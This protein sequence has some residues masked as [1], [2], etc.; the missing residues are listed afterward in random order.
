M[1]SIDLYTI[2][3]R[4][5]ELYGNFYLP[6]HDLEVASNTFLLHLFIF[7][8]FSLPTAQVQCDL[9]L[10]CSPKVSK[11]FP[12]CNYSSLYKKSDV[13]KTAQTVSK[14]LGYFCKKN[15][16]QELSKIAQ[17]AYTAQVGLC[18]QPY[19]VLQYLNFA[20]LLMALVLRGRGGWVGDC[21][22]L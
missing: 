14:H 11:S 17:S 6:C 3:V 16:H 5:G 18:F 9:M 21:M 20:D 8:P 15:C 22:V 1:S 7:S 19:L 4:K 10:K 2:S 12:K 13:F